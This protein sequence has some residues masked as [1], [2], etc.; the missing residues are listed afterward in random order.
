MTRSDIKN[1]VKL[2]VPDRLLW[3]YQNRNKICQWAKRQIEYNREIRRIRRKGT[4]IKVL[5]IVKDTVEW[6]YDSV[7][8]LMDKDVSFQPLILVCPI[9]SYTRHTPHQ[10]QEIFQRTYDTFINRGYNVR[11]ACDNLNDESINVEDLS[12]DIIFYSNLWVNYLADKYSHTYLKKFLKCYVDY[13][14]CNIAEEWGYS[15]PFHRLMW[16]YYTECED[17]KH[18]AL[19]AQPIEMRNAVVTGYPIYDEYMSAKGDTFDWKDANPKYK[20]IIWAPHHSIEGHQQHLHFSTFLE[21]AD[22]MLMIAK[23][24]KDVVQFVFK[25]HP[26]LLKGLYDHPAWGKAKADKYYQLWVE[27]ENTSL[28]DGTYMEL[29]KSSDAMIHDCGSFIVEYLYTQNPVLYLGR[30]REEQSNIV[31]KK[32]YSCHY[33]G[34][35]ISDIEHFIDDVVLKG[36]DDMKYK[37]Q[38]FFK[39]VL[40]PPNGCSVAENIVNDI[41]HAL[42]I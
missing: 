14:Y 2:F 4:P 17:M 37:R 22:A 26:L 36:N 5:F 38:Q 39:E 42:H 21:N 19:T 3:L 34:N 27:G 32:A 18:L 11:K 20:R 1:T 6:K 23:K 13:G 8:R 29:F 30:G 31:S 35:S 24:Y 25:P 28:V 40:L 12:P 15:S 10:A 16:R 33:H 41:K 7:Y 9:I